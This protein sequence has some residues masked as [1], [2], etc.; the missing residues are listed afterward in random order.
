VLVGVLVGTDAGMFVSV[1]NEACVFSEER[2]SDDEHAAVMRKM[3]HTIQTKIFFFVHT[4]PP[5]SSLSTP[6]VPIHSV[7]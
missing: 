1:G 5:V 3:L 4:S 2:L 7:G 6:S